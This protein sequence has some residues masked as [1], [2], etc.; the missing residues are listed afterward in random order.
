MDHTTQ[1]TVS[2][3]YSLR[4]FGDGL[5]RVSA[6]DLETRLQLKPGG[7]KVASEG[8]KLD[9]MEEP[10]EHEGVFW[11]GELHSYVL[12]LLMRDFAT[13]PVAPGRGSLDVWLYREAPRALGEVIRAFTRARRGGVWS[14]ERTAPTVE[15]MFV[16]DVDRPGRHRISEEGAVLL[17]LTA[18]REGTIPLGL[19]AALER[20]RQ[21]FSKTTRADATVPW[22]RADAN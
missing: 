3:G 16:E 14:V 6:A 11:L 21:V 15:E 13:K 20:T 2:N 8:L 5:T 22:L 10:V 1:L 17:G 12:L 9:G 19:G 4:A 18:S 7:L